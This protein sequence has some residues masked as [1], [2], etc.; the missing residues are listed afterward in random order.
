MMA[1]LW[2]GVA[3]SPRVVL[4]LHALTQTSLLLWQVW[5][6]GWTLSAADLLSHV[7]AH[8]TSHGLIGLHSLYAFLKTRGTVRQCRLGCYLRV[9]WA[10]AAAACCVIALLTTHWLFQ[11]HEATGRSAVE[12]AVVESG[13]ACD[14]VTACAFL[15]SVVLTV[16]A[17]LSLSLQHTAQRT[18]GRT[19]AVAARVAFH[20]E[21][22]WAQYSWSPSSGQL[23]CEAGFSASQHAAVALLQL[24]WGLVAVSEAVPFGN[25]RASLVVGGA[26]YIYYLSDLHGLLVVVERNS[27]MPLALSPSA[28]WH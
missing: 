26:F 13:A 25:L 2:P 20:A 21:L 14:P 7:V 5:L 15:G 28:P 10:A 22:L 17:L 1:A 27:F 4:S 12:G 11:G 18:V 8:A 23:Q 3:L 6:K 16:D 24:A 19:V 9:A